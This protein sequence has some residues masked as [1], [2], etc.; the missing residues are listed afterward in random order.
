MTKRRYH[1]QHSTTYKYDG[2]VELSHNQIR[3]TPQRIPDVQNPVWHAI[4]I[5]PQPVARRVRRD[6][7]GNEV[8]YF[9][10][11]SRHEEMEIVSECLVETWPAPVPD[12]TGGLGWEEALQ[13]MRASTETWATKGMFFTTPTTLIEP[14]AELREFALESFQPGRPLREAA[15]D[16]MSRVFN[17]F[18]FDPKATTISTPLSEVLAGRKGVCQDFAHLAIGCVRSLGLAARYVSG[19]IETVPPPGKERL[20]GADA[21]HAW[22]SVLDPSTGDWLDLDPTNNIMPQGQHVVMSYGR[23]YSDVPPV[24]GL[25]VG[26][27]SH[28]LDV[29]VDVIP[30]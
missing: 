13:T 16:L 22:F 2:S 8:T 26:S 7:F 20:V 30:Q 14:S 24:K 11:D 4:K 9:E 21:S 18:E 10:I 23:D 1:I 12:P 5:E 28:K 17:E 6:S 29:A 19:Y 25:T 27:G 3:L 15:I